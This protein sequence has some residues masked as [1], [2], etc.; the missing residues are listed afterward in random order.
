M[1][2]PAGGLR[3]EAS[4]MIVPGA[5]RLN[6]ARARARDKDQGGEGHEKNDCSKTIAGR[7]GL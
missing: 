7:T 5:G 2:A 1:R 3:A 6:W 4:W